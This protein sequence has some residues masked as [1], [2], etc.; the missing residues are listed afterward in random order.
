MRLFVAIDLPSA[1]KAVIGRA[2]ERLAAHDL[3]I[4]WLPA[5]SLHITL[6]FLGETSEQQCA[7]II[8]VLRDVAAA[9]ARFEIALQGL[10]AFPTL[11][12]PNI[13]WLGVEPSAQLATLQQQVDAGC[14]ALGYEV[15]E[16]AFKPHITIGK[17]KARQRIRDRAAVTRMTADFDYR[18][19][20]PVHALELMQS[21]L[22]PQGARYETLATMELN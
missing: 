7:S 6:K 13:F 1:E 17:T 21:H 9:N 20:V 18:A 16:R 19:R 14:T 4:R 2:L 8:S 12:R 10:G 5:D 3:P 11:G 15:E 22:G